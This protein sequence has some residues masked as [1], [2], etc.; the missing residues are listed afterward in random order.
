MHIPRPG[1]AQ[2]VWH[3]LPSSGRS[4]A[5]AAEASQAAEANG[6]AAAKKR[7]VAKGGAG[8]AAN[9]ADESMPS[10]SGGLTISEASGALNGHLH[11]VAGV[12]W[13][14]SNTVYSG[15]WDHSVSCKCST[16]V[17]AI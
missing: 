3:M 15:G 11:C 1:M 17:Y 7:K 12:T 6:K 14:S 16:C 10:P 13:P 8:G 4:I 9:G 5:E 2:H